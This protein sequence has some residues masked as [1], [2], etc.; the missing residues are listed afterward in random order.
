MNY[1]FP[2]SLSTVLKLFLLLSAGFLVLLALDQYNFLLAHV[3][4]EMFSVAV[5][6]LIFFIAWN[7]YKYIEHSF[8]TIAGI[9]Y[10]FVGML[11]LLHSIAYKGMGVFVGY[12][13]NLPTE[14]WI[15]ARL[16]ESI[17][18]LCA[19]V[20]IRKKV[21]VGWILTGWAVVF[22]A[23]LI[24]VFS[25]VFP[26]CFVP[27]EGLT[28]FKKLS[29]LGIVAIL[30]VAGVF[31]YKN[32]GYF[33]EKI[34]RYLYGSILLTMCAEIAFIVYIDVYDLSNL[35]GHYFKI[36]SF[37][38][39]YRGIVVTTFKEPYLI[40]MQRLQQ[41]NRTLEQ[42]RLEI[43]KAKRISETMLNNIPE[44]IALLD[45][46][47]LQIIDVN[48]TFLDVHGLSKSEVIGQHCYKITHGS[49]DLCDDADHPCPLV[50]VA[51]E[52]PVVHTHIN[53][54]GEKRF[55]EVSVWPVQK[56]VQNTTQNTVDNAPKE[57]EEIVHISRDITPQKR[58]EQLR[59]DVERV[60]RHDLK[61]P[62]NGII[63][64]ARLLLDYSNYTEEQQEL[65]E[66]IHSSGISVLKMVDN[67]MDL[68][69]MEEGLYQIKRDWFDLAKL[70]RRLSG[71]WVS[72]KEAKQVG[73]EFFI[74]GV[75][76]H[77]QS[78]FQVFAEEQTMENLLANLI[79]NA[80]DAAP[81]SSSVT[82]KADYT[83]NGFLLDV[84][85]YG[86]IPPEIRGRFFERYVSH[87]K[88][89]GT[90]LGTYSARLITSAHGGSIWFT[91]NE[92]EGT[93]LFVEIP[94]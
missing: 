10:F 30:L 41:R 12:T 33:S 81:A 57:A 14:L 13:A 48:Q 5:A 72:M 15:T 18:L 32:R 64:G 93:H 7:G 45:R 60:V 11:D 25:G 42:Q 3:L 89:H 73:L 24:L 50:D 67:S 80:L 59:D 58:I 71:R 4:A 38:L 84:H 63:G 85:N 39:M 94:S 34:L 86:V 75:V 17:A 2:V 76:L 79:E 53:N 51:S 23:A 31:L 35:I 1:K 82:V 66:A 65:I 77:Y 91:S 54:N 90:G 62:L 6:W 26:D 43:D 37:Y 70:F 68:Y 61:S 47:T 19:V 28:Q 49:D 21:P 36:L 55:V 87:G 16:L 74:S 22:F 83:E 27:G 29:E 52:Q 88:E 92:T 78:E 46:D 69:K 20:F 40:L 9:A 8:F 56:A 44:E